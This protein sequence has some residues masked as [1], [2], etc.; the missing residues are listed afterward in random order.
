M[1]MFKRIDSTKLSLVAV[2]VA[3]LLFVAVNVVANNW[4]GHLRADFTAGRS[5]TTSSQIKPIFENISEP[6]I[7]R[8]YYSQ[9][10]G[11][12]SARHGAYYQRVRDLLQQYAKLAK[13]NIKLELYNPAPFSDV[14]DRAV[15]FGLQAI[16]L[17]QNGEVG[18]FGLAAT[19][20]TDDQQVVPFFSI[21]REKFLEYDLTKLFYNLARPNQPKIGLITSLPL[22]GKMP[23]PQEMGMTGGAPI[24]PWAIMQQIKEFFAVQTLANDVPLIPADIDMLLLV[25]P[26][27]LSQ[28]TLQAIDQY[29]LGGGKVL[30]FI[31]PNAESATPLAAMGG[32]GSTGRADKKAL[33]GIKHVMA[34]WGVRL[35]ENQVVGDLDSAIRVNMAANG[36]PIL[37]DYVAW[38]RLQSDN[39]DLNDAI[40]GNLKELNVA[41]AGALEP[42]EGAGTTLTPLITTGVRSMRIDVDKFTGMPDI[43]ALF[44]DFKPQG[45]RE[46]V[47]VRITG[48]AKSAFA[49][50]PASALKESK[51]PIQVI[52]VADTD[53]LVDRFWIEMS[54]VMGQKVMVPTSDNG[55]FVSNAL[56]NMTGAPALSSLR[57]RGVQSRPFTL[58][59]DIRRDAE[60]QYRAKEQGLTSHLEELEKKAN[61][62]Q[63]KRDS[64]GTAVLSDDD[65]KTIDSYRADI[66][67]TRRELRDVQ[68][69]LRENIERLQSTI[70]FTNIGGVPIIFGLILIAVAVVRHRRRRRRTTDL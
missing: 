29:V 7:V 70:T 58:L 11:E 27:N 15:G 23:S 55:N 6:I 54:D 10:L 2:A 14:E 1:N 25:Q 44:R 9:A 50:V 49:D 32:F 30:L 19:N 67:A 51:Q 42:V 5:Y 33:D 69:A 39:L 35:V 18:Y 60:M 47:A 61:A 36:R 53:M 22:E 21:E 63:V 43:V 4:F 20:S 26:E 37:S 12:V 64:S 3:A 45:K 66:L 68:R 57:G 41:T 31:D 65:K 28:P 59:D 62:M 38:M 16:P 52:V 24:P 17:S 56:E 34:S 13:G 48:S 8:L 46:A 40:T